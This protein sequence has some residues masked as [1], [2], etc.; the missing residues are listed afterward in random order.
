MYWK[1]IMKIFRLEKYNVELNCSSI[2]IQLI[3]V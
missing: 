3:K 1:K 2:K